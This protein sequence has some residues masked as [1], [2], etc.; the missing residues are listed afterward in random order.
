MSLTTKDLEAIREIVEITVDV[1]LEEKLEEKFEE[2][3]KYLPNKEEFYASQDKL[4]K[5][6]RDLRDEVTTS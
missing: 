3:L 1:K 4:M 6:I 5:E 2:K